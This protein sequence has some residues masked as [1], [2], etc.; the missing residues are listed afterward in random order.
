M[1]DFRSIPHVKYL[2]EKY[3]EIDLGLDYCYEL[4]Q[5][6]YSAAYAVWY[7]LGLLLGLFFITCFWI[8]NQ[9]SAFSGYRNYAQ[10]IQLKTLRPTVD[11]TAQL[12]SQRLFGEPIRYDNMLS[13]NY[14]VE[15]IL[16]DEH[17]DKRSVLLKESRGE[18]KFYYEGERL[19]SGEVLKLIK[20]NS[21]ELENQGVRQELKIE[22]YPASFLSDKPLE[23]RNSILKDAD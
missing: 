20:K 13:S 14:K 15:A 2:L 6:S 18:G 4:W 17:A 3:P 11:Y 22:Q 19:P 12:A 16:Y 5:A 10:V 1:K 7:I 21:V 9:I 23:M 8:Q